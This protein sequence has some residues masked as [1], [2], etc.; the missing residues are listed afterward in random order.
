MN[1]LTILVCALAALLLS[2]CKIQNAPGA[3]LPAKERVKVESVEP[4]KS[5][6]QQKVVPT[7]TPEPIMV[8]DE[9]PADKPTFV[10]E[11]KPVEEP[12]L[13][14]EEKPVVKEEPLVPTDNT[15]RIQEEKVDVVGGDDIVLKTFNVVI[16]SFRSES[17]AHNLQSQMRPAYN[18]IVV[19]NEKGMFR[20]ILASYDSYNETRSKVDAIKNQFPD[21]WVLIQ[22]K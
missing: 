21:A 15:T 8:V 3:Y 7:P 18:P 22:K 4:E 14:V 6:E 20:V 19:V 13:V 5:A 1:R 16:G 11:P 10:E 9:K 2:A 12:K 17:N